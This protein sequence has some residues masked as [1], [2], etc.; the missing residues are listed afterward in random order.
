MD[1]ESDVRKA[2]KSAGIKEIQLESPPNPEFGDLSFPCF[3]IG[4]PAK[5]KALAVAIKPKGL[6]AKVEQVG[7]YVNFFVDT[8]KLVRSVI[9][10]VLKKDFGK[11]NKRGNALI[12][13]TSINPNASPHVGRAR[14]GLIGDSIARLLKFNGY[15]TEVHYFVNDI[16]K[17]IA[18]LVY[19]TMEMTGKPK[20]EE[21]LRHYIEINRRVMENV[22]LEKDILELLHQ[23]ETGNKKVIKE[24]EDIV[25]VCVKGLTKIL[26]IG[27]RIAV[28]GKP[29]QKN[30]KKRWL[31]SKKIILIH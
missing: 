19:G 10:E 3:K 17:Q 12:E 20:F 26:M 28:D 31:K 6:I 18:M 7:P 21:L 30:L 24:F 1:F 22:Q 16:G 8:K 4:G 15:K 9:K 23:V 14:N 13:H 27:R 11:G 5:A 25:A 2:L 29:F